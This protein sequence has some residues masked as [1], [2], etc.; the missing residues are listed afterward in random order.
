M[1]VIFVLHSNMYDFFPHGL[2]LR[3]LDPD[4][5]P[6]KN[7]KNMLMLS[8]GPHLYRKIVNM[9]LNSALQCVLGYM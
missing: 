5:K 1:N 8:M 4:L 3:D 6:D 2:I 9:Y 7:L